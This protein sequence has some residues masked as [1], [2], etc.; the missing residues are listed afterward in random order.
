MARYII[1][2]ILLS[3][4]DI[5]I[6]TAIDSIINNDPDL[7]T[8]IVVIDGL[9]N[10]SVKLLIE[11]KLRKHDVLV[12]E[13]DNGIFDALNKG[14]V[15]SDAPYIG[16][17]G[18]DDYFTADI[19]FEFITECLS[20]YD[21]YMGRLY[22]VNQGHVIR[23]VETWPCKHGLIRM[24]LNNPHFATFGKASLLKKFKFD[25]SLRGADIKYFIDIFSLNP[26]CYFDDSV[27]V[28]M[29][30]GGFSNGSLRGVIKTNVQLLK[31]YGY[32]IGIFVLIF[33][34]SFKVANKFLWRLKKLLNFPE[35]RV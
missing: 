22:Y 31:V 3:Y 26:R 32:K 1:D 33:K 5:K 16:W 7:L 2:I 19:D 24:G 30:E 17:L 12:Y 14:L 4:N 10:D 25:L 18:S 13:R 21:L 9:S 28:H 23:S 27:I 35:S 15:F 8:R 11:R 6:T 29:S 34:G 20:E